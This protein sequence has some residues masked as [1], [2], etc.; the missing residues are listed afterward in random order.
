MTINSVGSVTPRSDAA[1]FR[2]EM[3]PLSYLDPARGTHH[4]A[5][6]TRSAATMIRVIGR[7]APS[8]TGDLHLGNL[9]T[10]VVVVAV[11]TV[12][13]IVGSWSGW[14]ISIGTNRTKPTNRRSSTTSPRS[15]STGT[16]T[17]FVRAIDSRST[18]TRSTSSPQR[19][20][21]YECFCTRREIQTGDRRVG[22][23]TTRP[24]RFVSRAPAATSTTPPV[25]RIGRR[26]GRRRSVCAPTT[27]RSPCTTG[28]PVTTAPSSTTS[29]CD[30]TTVCPPTTSPSW[31][32]TRVQGIERG[33]ARRRPAVVDPPPGDAP[34][35]ARVRDP[36]STCTSRS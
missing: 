21:V 14:K 29:C 36:V 28:S 19:D 17:S 12:G 30:E 13:G 35:A 31:S 11:G 20:L 2:T 27:R 7:F 23:R 25:P 26:D 15:G 22:G 4:R 8:P 16:A 6:C 24:A 18:T 33:G 9:R 32:T 3:L 10:A 1:T 5:D 34:A